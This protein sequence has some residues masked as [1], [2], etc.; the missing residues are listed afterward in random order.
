MTAR[1]G[2]RP[3]RPK[4]SWLGRDSGRALLAGLLLVGLFVLGIA[5]NIGI[6]SPPRNQ[7]A[8]AAVE[9]KDQDLT[10]GSILFVPPTGNACRERLIDNATWRIRDKGIVDCD[11]A[12]ARH[13]TVKARQW[14]SQRVDVIRGGFA[15][16]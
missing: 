3:Q 16:R 4:P 2:T 7:A 11:T 9:D 1:F 8:Q 6:G 14:S 15:G 5:V 13:A 12:L 10:T